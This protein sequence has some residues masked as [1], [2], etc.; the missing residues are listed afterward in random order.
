[1]IRPL[2]RLSMRYQNRETRWDQTGRVPSGWGHVK[3][4]SVM[5]KALHY[6][7]DKWQWR[8]AERPG[9]TKPEEMYPDGYEVPAVARPRKETPS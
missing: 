4:P 3:E 9:R 1:M 8:S 7:Y 5:E 2:R 6:L